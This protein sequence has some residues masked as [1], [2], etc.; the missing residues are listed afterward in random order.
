M[1]MFDI[2]M[3]LRDALSGQSLS[4]S[5]ERTTNHSEDAKVIHA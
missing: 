5:R 3:S 4:R 2:A 1:T